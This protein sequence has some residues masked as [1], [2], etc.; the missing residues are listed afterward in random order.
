MSIKYHTTELQSNL[1]TLAL[2][3]ILRQSSAQIGLELTVLPQSPEFWAHLQTCATK[4]FLLDF[5]YW[6]Y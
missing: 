6:N 3:F 2:I 5:G 4:P 1:L